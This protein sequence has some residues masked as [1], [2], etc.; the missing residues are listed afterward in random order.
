[1]PSSDRSEP[2]VTD[3][4]S[5]PRGHTAFAQSNRP[6]P[7][8]E[9][10]QYFD[11]S[12]PWDAQAAEALTCLYEEAADQLWGRQET[13]RTQRR[14]APE[15]TSHTSDPPA[16][17]SAGTEAR[18]AALVQTMQ[19]TVAGLKPDAALAPIHQ[20]IGALEQRLSEA[21]E[22]VARRSDVDGLR[23]IQT[24]VSDL[25]AHVERIF[26]SLD[27]I[28]GLD[29]QV[30]ELSRRLDEDGLQRLE[31]LERTL[32]NYVTEWRRSDERTTGTLEVLDETLTRIH[33]SIDAADALKPA[34][35]LSLKDASVDEADSAVAHD[36]LAQVYSEGRRALAPLSQIDLDAADY[37]PG[38]IVRLPESF[39]NPNPVGDLR[40]AVGDALA[41]EK[42]TQPLRAEPAGPLHPSDGLQPL[43]DLEPRKE[44]ELS[45]PAFRA[46]AIRARLQKK[47]ML[48]AATT[49]A[50]GPR[51]D[52]LPANDTVKA[53]DTNRARPSVLL[54]AGVTLFAA[55]GY[56]LVDVFFSPH[57][58][59]PRQGQTPVQE[60]R[61]KRAHDSPAMESKQA[62]RID[63][64][65]T[66]IAAVF[67]EPVETAAPAVHANAPAPTGE[68]LAV[69]PV[70]APP[71]LGIGPA[72]LRQAAMSGD[73][74]AQY[75]VGLRYAS[76]RDI[77]Q[78]LVAAFQWHSRA[79][80]RGLSAA[81]FRLAAMY[82]RG[83]GAAPD[84]E[85]ARTWYQRA[86]EQG[87]VKA[88][89]NLAV[90]SA[91]GGRTD[92][93]FAAKWFTEAAERGLA[94][95]QFN[96][97]VLHQNGMGVPKDLKAAYKWLSLAAR[98]G[99]TDA[100]S[101]LG[102]IKTQLS[103]ADLRATDAVIE[104][105]RVRSPDPRAAEP[106]PG[107]AA[108]P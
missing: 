82:E 90:L 70:I 51:L 46:S 98:S 41:Q 34:A 95:S 94:D 7:T 86:A 53:N 30:R 97:A 104:A 54:A 8:K 36:A 4:A 11:P 100:A 24:Q 16:D 101:R 55:A 75:E 22:T 5:E 88:M 59:V 31:T 106:S 74:I 6:K 99:D 44:A 83:Q 38:A 28:D 45:A 85:K 93:A 25:A 77:P 71:A 37:T 17:W 62:G 49:S 13:D 96:L 80:A 58:E 43:S 102:A 67:R 12:D 14:A 18:V 50:D 10:A 107:L 72:S 21:M 23:L 3:P 20:R 39:P 64:I 61:D 66:A 33:T 105:W 108:R 42:L 1:M 68:A 35:S 91:G 60:R 81:Q 103:P 9:D 65:G 32:Q 69:G 73:P 92:Y 47:Q 52:Q 27:R 56:L 57:P 89:H 79:A 15:P 19:D 63:A 29:N 48:E 76:G 84:I 87:H 2:R 78:D 40:S 26:H